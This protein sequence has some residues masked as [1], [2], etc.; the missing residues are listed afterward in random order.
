V[1]GP[2]Y[3]LQLSPLDIFLYVVVSC[4]VQSNVVL[5]G[6]SGVGHELKLAFAMP[7]PKSAKFQKK[8]KKIKK[9]F[10]GTKID[11]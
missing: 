11:F 4:C 9:G 3:K 6:G 5:R 2:W 8:N 1:A 10:C 7:V